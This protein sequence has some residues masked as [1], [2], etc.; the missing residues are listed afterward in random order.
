MARWSRSGCRHGRVI[1]IEEGLPLEERASDR[2]QT[3]THGSQ[4]PAMAMTT[5]TQL[6]IAALADRVALA[7]NASPVIDRVSQ[8]PV[9]G[10]TPH[11]AAALAAAEGHRR[12]TTQGPQGV[13]ISSTHR[14]PSLGEQRGDD[15]PS[16]SRH[17]A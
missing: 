6:D 10:I 5:P 12:N 17:G 7:G 1:G 4:R 14:L 16:D 3:V 8:P 13:I 2:E 9:A 11:H 15:N